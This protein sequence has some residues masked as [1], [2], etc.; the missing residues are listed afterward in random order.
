MCNYRMTVAKKKFYIF[1]Y[2]EKRQNVGTRGTWD[3]IRRHV[4]SI[5]TFHASNNFG[6]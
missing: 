4:A 5:G 6:K 1:Q 3:W 2:V